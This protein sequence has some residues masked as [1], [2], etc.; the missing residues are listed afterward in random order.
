[1]SAIQAP[2]ERGGSSSTPAEPGDFATL[3]HVHQAGVW[4]YLRFS[5]A[6]STEAEELTQE[7]FLAFVGA[8]FVERD[9][10]QTACYLRT[11]AHNQLLA[12]RRSEHRGPITIEFEAAESIWAAA[13]AEGQRRVPSAASGF[14]SSIDV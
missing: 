4:R 11:I 12:I 8:R 3:I 5:G 13:A 1:M 2:P 14:P 7:T 6:S 9:A 10:R